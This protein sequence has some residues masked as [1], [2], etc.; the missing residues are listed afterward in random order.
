MH[1]GNP[2]LAPLSFIITPPPPFDNRYTDPNTIM[3]G[4][5]LRKKG[6][7]LNSSELPV[8][9]SRFVTCDLNESSHGG[10]CA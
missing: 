2:L 9:Q 8:C 3:P 4:S 7:A 5:P 1:S 6:A 10:F